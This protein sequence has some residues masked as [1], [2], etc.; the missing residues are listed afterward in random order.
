MDKQYYKYDKLR[1]RI[2]EKY[3]TQKAFAE[4]LNVSENS[5]SLKMNCKTEFSQTDMDKFAKLLEIPI[6]EYSVYFFA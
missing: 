1:G 6:S 3:G 4:A 5:L 2:V